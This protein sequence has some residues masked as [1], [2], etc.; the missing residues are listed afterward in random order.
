MDQLFVKRNQDGHILILVEKFV[1]DL[2]I[3]GHIDSIKHFFNTLRSEFSLGA[4]RTGTDLKFLGCKQKVDEGGSMN[5]S[6]ANY[7]NLVKP[8]QLSRT[9][10]RQQN[11]LFDDRERSEYRSL[12]GVLL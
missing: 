10:R 7:L 11:E 12:A 2:L 6:M 5:F 8:T 3:S 1:D 4:T 9:S